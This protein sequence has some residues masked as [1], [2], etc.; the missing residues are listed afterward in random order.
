MGLGRR[1]AVQV[2]EEWSAGLTLG[3]QLSRSH[4][5]IVFRHFDFGR[6]GILCS[7]RDLQL[8]FWTALSPPL[9]RPHGEIGAD[10]PAP[11]S[12][13]SSLF[14]GY[15]LV[16]FVCAFDAVFELAPVVE[17]LL[18]H[19]VG[20]AGNFATDRSKVD[21]L[22]DVE[23]VRGWQPRFGRQA[24]SSCATLRHAGWRPQI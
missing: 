24:R 19:F 9:G 4:A 13:V 10:R 12:F 21:N 16:F 7:T 3:S 11:Y 22:T 2:T 15:G 20:A 23:F 14:S 1:A 6:S 18:D 5:R 17:E 8:F